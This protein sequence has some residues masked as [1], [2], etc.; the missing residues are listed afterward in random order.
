MAE[1]AHGYDENATG[2]D[3]SQAASSR[4]QRMWRLI[5][6]HKQGIGW[7]VIGLN[8]AIGIPQIKEHGEELIHRGPAYAVAYGGF[9]A[10][11][12]A[13]GGS[14]GV[15]AIQRRRAEQQELA[16]PEVEALRRRENRSVLV[17]GGAGLG[18]A[19]TLAVATVT[20]LPPEAWPAPL[21]LL[22]VDA[23]TTVGS[24]YLVLHDRSNARTNPAPEAA[25][26]EPLPLE[27]L[28]EPLQSL[29]PISR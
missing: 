3:E 15:S 21:V 26:L 5:K 20:L 18:A 23:M 9:L 19:G 13:T 28:V 24:R 1:I 17:N 2:N 4:L 14:K 12:V 10:L 7:G 27:S 25:V 29:P 22:G 11:F 16:E 6:R 8:V